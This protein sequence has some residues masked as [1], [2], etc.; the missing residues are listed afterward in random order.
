M[1]GV[2]LGDELRGRGAR[3]V[4]AV[5]GC[6]GGGGGGGGAGGRPGRPG[7]GG[8]GEGQLL[9]LHG[10]CAIWGKQSEGEI[11]REKGHEEIERVGTTA[12]RSLP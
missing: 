11:E 1:G 10:G 6:G 7:L 9:L 4:L 12:K 3:G 2:E 5:V 8:D